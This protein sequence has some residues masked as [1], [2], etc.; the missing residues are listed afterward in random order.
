VK[1]WTTPDPKRI[2]DKAAEVSAISNSL[3]RG[4]PVAIEMAQ[5]ALERTCRHGR[6]A[7]W[8]H[9]REDGA[10]QGF[11]P[12]QDCACRQY[13]PWRLGHDVACLSA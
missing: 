9:R 11:D 2:I 12:T 4:V 3:R 13:F 5:A 7:A 1:R 10:D 6:S 8:L